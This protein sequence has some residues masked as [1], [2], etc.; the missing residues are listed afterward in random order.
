[1]A[2]AAALLLTLVCG[3][4]VA[5]ATLSAG[6]ERR[7]ASAY[8]SG[9][10]LRHAAA[11][12][13]ALATAELETRAWGPPLAGAGSS[14]W[15]R[16]PSASAGVPAL[17]EVIRRETMAAAAHGADTPVWQRFFETPWAEVVGHVGSID[18]MVWIADDWQERDGEPRVDSNGLLLIRAAAVQ[19]PAVAWAEGLF[20]LGG[21]G[22]LRPDHVRVW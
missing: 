16:P 1:M 21:D 6:L 18:L 17:E 14:L 20:R 7:A 12:G 4:L 22:R 3:S 8:A 15:Q 11:G 10:A 13:L 5:S 2:L 19:G 9:A